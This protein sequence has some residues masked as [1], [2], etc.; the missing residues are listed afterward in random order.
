MVTFNPVIVWIIFV[1]LLPA[2]AALHSYAPSP[3]LWG[4]APKG[5]MNSHSTLQGVKAR[6][7]AALSGCLWAGLSHAKGRGEGQILSLSATAAGMPELYFYLSPN[8][9]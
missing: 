2:C 7:W 9:L 1:R 4:R 5:A 6:G 8:P 3:D